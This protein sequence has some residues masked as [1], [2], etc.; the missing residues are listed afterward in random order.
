M[1][2]DPTCEQVSAQISC[3]RQLELAKIVADQETS[4]LRYM[5]VNPA[6][7]KYTQLPDYGVYSL[8][9]QP[10][11]KRENTYCRV[12]DQVSILDYPNYMCETKK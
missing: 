12:M 6:C 11:L 1:S 3:Q 9:G 8:Q 7:S 4:K 5:I 2:Y 10:G